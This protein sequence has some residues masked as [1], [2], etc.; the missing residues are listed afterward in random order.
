MKPRLSSYLSP[1]LEVRRITDSLQGIFAL[2]PL[3]Q[4]EIIAVWGGDA[5]TGAQIKTMPQ[6]VVRYGV[7]VEDDVYLISFD[8]SPADQMNH[9]CDPNAGISGQIVVV[10]MRDIAATEQ[11]TF[12]YAMT[13][14]SD[15]D[16][17]DCECNAG[18]CRKRVTGNDWQLPELQER[19]NGYFAHYL[20]RR[21]DA[22]RQARRMAQV[23]AD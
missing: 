10:A 17:F 12:D 11:I 13:D 15:Y 20:Q 3:K 16:E 2:E 9:S 7:Q 14:S 4:G 6:E 1:K 23:A 5:L 8:V 19:Y 18:T 22:E 21:I